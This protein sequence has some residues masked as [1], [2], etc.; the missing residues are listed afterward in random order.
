MPTPDAT[1]ATILLLDIHEVACTPLWLTRI[2]ADV[3]WPAPTIVTLI[4][5]VVGMFDAAAE[6]I[7]LTYV[8]DNVNDDTA[9]PGT[10]VMQAWPAPTPD[11]T[12]AAIPLLDFHDVA[13]IPVPPRRATA[14]V[15]NA[16]PTIVTLLA[17]VPALL[18]A[19][20][21]ESDVPPNES[22]DAIDKTLSG[23]DATTTRSRIVPNV[24]LLLIIDVD[25]QKVTTKPDPP[26]RTA[27]DVSLGIVPTNVTVVDPVRTIFDGAIDGK[28]GVAYD[29]DLL[30]VATHLDAVATQERLDRIPSATFPATLLLERHN[31][32]PATLKPTS[33][34]IDPAKPCPT[35]VT[36]AAPVVGT[37][38]GAVVA[39]DVLSYDSNSVLACDS[40]LLTLVS[41]FESDTHN[42]DIGGAV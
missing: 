35:T 12:F 38:E 5:P 32:A 39:T 40:A 2:A 21:E 23:M 20:N 24:D 28:R 37:F 31:V 42:V 30:I 41:T 10:V 29:V 8:N 15:A 3:A 4:A 22:V 33:T 36:L 16:L 1:L 27:T 19:A 11:A 25:C 26:T 9:T 13:C 18:V 34:R 17:P 6:L 7:A 14:D